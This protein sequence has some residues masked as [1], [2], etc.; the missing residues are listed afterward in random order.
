M[1]EVTI[2]L[3]EG[4]D[5]L[6]DLD[7]GLLVES[8]DVNLAA[9][10][11]T[12]QNA[13][14]MV[15]EKVVITNFKCFDGEFEMDFNDG[16]NIIVGDNDAGKSTIIEAV[17]LALTG[18]FQGRYLKDGLT[19]YM[20]NNGVVKRYLDDLAVGKVAEPPSVSIDIYFKGPNLAR[21]EGNGNRRNEK[22]CGVSYVIEF[23]D[24]YMTEYELLTK[25]EPLATL[26]IEYY[27]VTW[28]T[29]AR[30][31]VTGRGIPI[32][33]ALIEAMASRMV[34]GSD[35]Y[36]SRIVRE[37]LD[38]ADRIGVAQ[39]HRKIRDIF[40]ADGS[41]TAVNA[42]LQAAV[43]V[44]DKK[45]TLAVDLA[46]KN[47]WETVLMTFI[48]QVPFHYIGRG[49]QSVIKTR[50]ALSHKKAL[51][52]SIL[53]IEEPEN[54]LTHTN[55]NRLIERVDRDNKNKQIIIST[56]SSYVANKLSLDNLI[57][58]NNTG[59]HS[60]VKLSA[61]SDQGKFFKKLPGYDTLR[62]ALA[63]KVVLV[64]GD[65]DELVVQKAYMLKHQGRLPIHLK[66]IF[67][68]LR[69]S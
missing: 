24:Q 64:E 25:K 17:N 54:H 20:F 9:P 16:I 63:E 47:A 55:L 14:R 38:E 33:S 2:G 66:L 60:Y 41:I 35:F 52:A 61:L 59:G 68:S 51:E 44:S 62:L 28:S 65:A 53:L 67:W 22:G 21:F 8:D 49:E 12:D 30:D 4:D 10:G 32:K 7:I 19:Q 26:P 36:I 3:P 58:L 39:A 45:V 69:K 27:A 56:H 34:N 48:N 15:I 23:D 57:L 37:I 5:V 18:F 42:K 11:Q 50:L 40:Q 43:D 46:T 29:F 1:S 6:D 13:S 31:K